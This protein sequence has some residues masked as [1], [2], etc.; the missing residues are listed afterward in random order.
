[1]LAGG[2]IGVRVSWVSG[3]KNQIIEEI[4][5]N[6]YCIYIESLLLYL[7]CCVCDGVLSSALCDPTWSL[8]GGG[9]PSRK[10]HLG[11]RN[12][13]VKHGSGLTIA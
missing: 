1:M 5:R 7:C 10:L 12:H 6:M 2:V 9:T 11:V 3:Y 8:N 4:G 13:Y